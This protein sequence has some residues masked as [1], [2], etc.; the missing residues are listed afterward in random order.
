MFTRETP[1]LC[2]VM[3]F[4]APEWG[5]AVPGLNSPDSESQAVQMYYGAAVGQTSN[6]DNSPLLLPVMNFAPTN[7]QKTGVQPPTNRQG[8]AGGAKQGG[9]DNEPLLLPKMF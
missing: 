5:P 7:V 3:N 8:R 6:S 1:L 2:P 4:E 9:G